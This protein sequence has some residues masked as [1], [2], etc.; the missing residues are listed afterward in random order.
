MINTFHS[1]DS[2]KQIN[3]TFAVHYSGRYPRF[4]ISRTLPLF[5]LF[6]VLAIL[7][8]DDEFRRVIFSR[9]T[10]RPKLFSSLEFS[11]LLALMTA[12][13]LDLVLA[14]KRVR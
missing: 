14:L 1:T 5:L 3:S 2:T 9:H 7:Y 11:F 8:I 4:Y 12:P 10:S 6:L 13:A